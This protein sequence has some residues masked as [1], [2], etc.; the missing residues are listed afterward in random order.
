MNVKTHRLPSTDSL[1][2]AA[3]DELPAPLEPSKE[4]LALMQPSDFAAAP[5]YWRCNICKHE[6]KFQFN[7]A[8]LY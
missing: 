2:A 8:A 7:N 1:A 4:N 5:K 6:E 3:A